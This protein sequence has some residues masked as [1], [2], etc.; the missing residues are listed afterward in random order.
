MGK[1]NTLDSESFTF[2]ILALLFGFII[3]LIIPSRFFMPVRVFFHN[4]YIKMNPDSQ[5]DSKTLILEQ[6]TK[7]NVSTPK[8]DIFEEPEKKENGVVL[9]IK[10]VFKK[11]TKQ[12][13][14]QTI[15]DFVLN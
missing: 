10:K 15:N 7:D 14:P 3:G 5:K 12:E 1:K 8:K 4:I 13:K 9:Y 6:V 11:D 2:I